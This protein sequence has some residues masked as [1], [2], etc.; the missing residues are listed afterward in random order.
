[1]I[2]RSWSLTHTYTNTYTH[3][4][5]ESVS[6]PAFGGLALRGAEWI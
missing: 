1:M 3:G 6:Q 4:A 5:N 2:S